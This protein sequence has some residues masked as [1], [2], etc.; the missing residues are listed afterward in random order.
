[1]LITNYYVLPSHYGLSLLTL[2]DNDAD[3]TC[4]QCH[5]EGRTFAHLR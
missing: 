5:D 1:M 2:D 3:F 4:L